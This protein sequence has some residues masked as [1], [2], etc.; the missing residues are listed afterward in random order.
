MALDSVTLLRVGIIITH[1]C[2]LRC[3]LCG[4]YSPY[5]NPKPHFTK[6]QIITT[7]DK[8]FSVVDHVGDISFS[9]GE[10][11]LHHDLPIFLE[12]A[13]K[14][15]SKY[16]RLLVLTNGTMLPDDLLL[17]EMKKCGE[18]FQV[19]ISNYGNDK[20][21]YCDNLK[22][23]LAEN[24]IK[25]RE[26]SYSGDKLFCDGWVDLR[27]HV[28]K[29]FTEDEIKNHAQMCLKQTGGQCFIITGGEMHNCARSYRRT[30]LGLI[31]KNPD[32]FVDFYDT[33]K[34]IEELRN[35]VKKMISKGFTTSC[36]YCDGVLPDSKR[37][38]P[39]EQLPANFSG[40]EED[41]FE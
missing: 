39:A 40:Q 34:S 17:N 21:I 10:P 25:Y 18:K 15:S 8:F 9:G 33:S 24:Q 1:R 36:A 2:T 4:S 16:D 5:Y 37:Y 32:E 38:V 41:T 7:I 22:N 14:Y 3:K 31:P 35:I 27:R 11:L 13:R 29:Y 28:Q 19:N 12:R 6:E 20:S 26:I 23:I 30:Y